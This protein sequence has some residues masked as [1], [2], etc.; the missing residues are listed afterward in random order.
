MQSKHYNRTFAGGNQASDYVPLPEQ[1]PDKPPRSYLP[2]SGTCHSTITIQPQSAAVLYF[3]PNSVAPFAIN[4]FTEP[5]FNTKKLYSGLA[6]ATD[7]AHY[8]DYASW[9]NL[10][11][12][13]AGAG[14]AIYFVGNTDPRAL[15]NGEPGNFANSLAEASPGSLLYQQYMGGRMQLQATAGWNTQC[16]ITFFDSRSYP[17]LFG[18]KLTPFSTI[19]F[20]N[21][22]A[23]PP[24]NL[25]DA[26]DT[27]QWFDP[28]P[29]KDKSINEV[30][31]LAQRSNITG[32]STKSSAYV[33]CNLPPEGCR[34][35]PWT[36][37]Y[38]NA[39]GALNNASIG[40]VPARNFLAYLSSGYPF[41]IMHNFG[42]A[43]SS[44]LLVEL[45][46]KLYYCSHVPTT[47]GAAVPALAHLAHQTRPH[48]AGTESIRSVP[49]IH[50]ES[51]AHASDA[52]LKASIAASERD[53]LKDAKLYITHPPE[54]PI[55][56]AKI[57]PS[58]GKVDGSKIDPKSV[59]GGALSG[60]PMKIISAL[61]DFD[62]EEVMKSASDF[63][64]VGDLLGKATG[65]LGML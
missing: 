53:G 20:L 64:E 32:G 21:G 26:E 30:L 55:E 5:D 56:T 52:T 49:I 27:F 13:D 35:C 19:G 57:C 42:A 25:P 60:D 46:S 62:P 43:G 34:W 23:A 65:L 6:V 18:S 31:A 4:T 10:S 28:Q 9:T 61:K 12:P 38:N 41:V 7:S 11:S 51:H 37:N 29:L 2:S 24:V 47:G 15:V 16:G 14:G 8:G 3:N 48:A 22:A 50:N 40:N 58:A 44:P 1:S 45:R 39:A 59:I 54:I 17:T 33:A 63:G 36:G